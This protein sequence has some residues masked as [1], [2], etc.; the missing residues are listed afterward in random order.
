ML[1]T[2]GHRSVKLSCECKCTVHGQSTTNVAMELTCDICFNPFG[3]DLQCPRMLTC[4]HTFCHKCIDKF[5]QTESPCPKCNVK[6]EQKEVSQVSVNFLAIS[7]LE[8]EGKPPKGETEESVLGATAKENSTQKGLLPYE[9]H[10]MDHSCPNHFMC[11]KCWKL[12]C[13]TCIFLNHQGCETVKISDALPRVQGDKTADLE[14][15]IQLLQ[16][17]NEQ[18]EEYIK[19]LNV[20]LKDLKEST[21]KVETNLEKETKLKNEGQALLR[22][23]KNLKD[24]MTSSDKIFE[25]LKAEEKGKELVKN[26]PIFKEQEILN[27]QTWMGTESTVSLEGIPRSDI[28]DYLK[29]SPAILCRVNRKVLLEKVII[30]YH[31]P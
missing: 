6:I 13:G 21:N 20:S 14:V 3:K 8:K 2:I 28:F 17:S 9:G 11:M 31:A 7:L 5:I 18:R 30:A 15:Q 19:K 22:T 16:Q 25:I 26:I 4:G 10:C 23:L 27:V 29:N 24:E 12:L 1:L